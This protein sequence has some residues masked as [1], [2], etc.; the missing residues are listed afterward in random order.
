MEGIGSIVTPSGPQYNGGL[1]A[2]GW[3]AVEQS[4][5]GVTSMAEF[6]VHCN[7]PQIL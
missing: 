3:K 1:G 7:S 5:H 4:H 6:E 2:I